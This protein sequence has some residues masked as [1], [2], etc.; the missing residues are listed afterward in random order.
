MLR[1]DNPLVE[2]LEP[3]P[4]SSGKFSQFPKVSLIGILLSGCPRL[5]LCSPDPG[6]LHSGTEWR[7]G[8]NIWNFWMLLTWKKLLFIIEAKHCQKASS[9]QNQRAAITRTSLFNRFTDGV[10]KE[11]AQPQRPQVPLHPR[12]LVSHHDFC[13]T[14]AKPENKSP[15]LL[16]LKRSFKPCPWLPCIKGFGSIICMFVCTLYFYFVC[17]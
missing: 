15:I 1:E 16:K 8:W 4:N 2:T 12:E 10:Y 7:Y 5:G 11:P 14:K 9:K 6:H 13:S 3:L 17:M